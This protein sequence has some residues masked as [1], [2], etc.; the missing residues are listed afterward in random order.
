MAGD[1]ALLYQ[2]FQG[3]VSE[4]REEFFEKYKENVDKKLYDERDLS[5]LR[6]DDLWVRQFLLSRK[7]V[8]EDAVVMMDMSLRWRKEWGVN[9]LKH[10]SFTLDF[11]EGGAVYF[12]SKD[13][14]GQKI[15][16]FDVQQCK[17]GDQDVMVQVKK[18]IAY[19]L[20]LS[21]RKRPGERIVLLMDMS[22]AGMSNVDLDLLKFL[23]TA[24][25]TNFP[26]LLAY[27]LIYEM[28][29]LFN[30]I[31]KIVKTWLNAEQSKR[32]I[33]V[34]KTGIQE[35]I[36]KEE[37]WEHMGGLDTY[38]YHYI[39]PTPDEDSPGSDNS[40]TGRRKQV[41]FAEQD[42]MYNSFDAS[43]EVGEDDKSDRLSM[44]SVLSRQSQGPGRQKMVSGRK[45]QR[46]DQN[47]YTGRLIIISPAD[48]LEFAVVDNSKETLDV[49]S[50]TNRMQ[51]QVAFKVKTTSPEKYRVRPSAGV[52]NPGSCVEV[53]V[54]LLPGFHQT[55][56]RDKFLVMA[57]E[58][59]ENVSSASDIHEM[60]KMASRES[61]TEHRL[62]CVLTQAKTDSE[63]DVPIQLQDQLKD[64]NNKLKQV[65]EE[66]AVLDKRLRHMFTLL[67]FV[68][69][70]LVLL[71]AVVLY[72]TQQGQYAGHLPKPPTNTC[73]LL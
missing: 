36:N 21:C 49:I 22:M 52:I 25:T 64:I 17:K 29:W 40:P 3:Q 20:E 55:I 19:H 66:N 54:Y 2:E 59:Q 11:W 61:V 12:H 57:M 73:S 34:K 6:S 24:F 26:A 60:W 32:V 23:I 18:F 53:N 68:I 27:F 43:G 47:I 13:K 39:P 16:Y 63:E 4:A 56:N 33:F 5:K 45:R 38:K 58:N 41:T 46:D 10:D 14:D 48:E 72:L 70:L 67:L 69:V 30:A 31:W 62:R 35:Y 7:G 9:D 71:L 28:P 51:K 8:V 65:L 37:L 1:A 42:T 50:L 44:S 15:L